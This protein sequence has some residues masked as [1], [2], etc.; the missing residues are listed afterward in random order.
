MSSNKPFE[1]EKEKVVF[2]PWGKEVWLELNEKYCYKR[3]YINAGYKTSYQYHHFKRETNYI[4]SGE[5]EIWLENDQGIVEKKICKAGDYFNVTPPKKHRVIALTDIILQEVSTPEVDDVIRIGDE[6]NRSDGKID[7]EHENPGVLI[8]A[9]G[10]G[11]RLKHLTKELN[12]ALLP[13]DNEAI[14]SKIIK[15]FPS[16]YKFVIA[17]GYKGEVI[18]EYCKIALPN[19]DITFVNVDDIESSSSGPGLSALKCKNYLQRPFYIT[20]ADCL[21]KSQMPHI[22]GNWLGLHST[23]YPEK[24]STALVKDGKITDFKGKSIN[25]FD[26]A[27]IGLASILDFE[28]FWN[29]LEKNIKHGE[30]VSA[31]ENPSNYGELFSKELVWY[32]TGNLDD[33]ES[34]KEVFNDKPLS[35][36]KTNSEV[37]YKENN[38]LIKFIPNNKD[39]QDLFARS[40]NIKDLLPSNVGITNSFLYYDWEPGETLYSIDDF[41]LYEKFIKKYISNIKR[42]DANQDDIQSFYIDKTIIRFNTYLNKN[43]NSY[44]ET[45]FNINGINFKSFKEIYDNL[46]LTSLKDTYFNENFHGDLQFD[47]ILFHNNKFTY[48]DWRR[49]FGSS[50]KAGDVYYDLAKLYGGI[51]MP[52]NLMKDES[53]ITLKEGSGF[54]EYS[55]KKLKG[56]EGIE[57]KFIKIIEKNGFDFN[58]IKLITGLIYLNMSP[59]HEGKFS[60]LLWFESIRILSD[61]EDK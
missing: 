23:S 11:T 53:N 37:T 33:L 4:I 9:A 35:L 47:N 15:Q 3:I 41:N 59:M 55:F 57:N 19:H 51:L 6:F 34:A 61:N 1:S 14:I 42:T 24:Y 13:I 18:K 48:I 31:F 38:R 30:L 32:D 45:C 50:L 52:Y 44:A 58:K 40:Q 26:K 10:K 7:S 49:N 60:K 22:D 29:E 28:I 27:F 16:D 39:L 46:D 56:I 20:T 12:K 5:A 54:V 17:L 25:G 36:S 8:L 21:I 43:G 2:K